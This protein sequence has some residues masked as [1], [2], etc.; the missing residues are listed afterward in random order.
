[1]DCNT[2]GSSVHGVSQAR[3]LEW[4]LISFS[5]GSSWARDWTWVSCISCIG[6]WLLYHW[7]TPWVM[8]HGFAKSWTQLSTWAPVAIITIRWM[9]M[10]GACLSV[11][12]FSL[13]S[14]YPICHLSSVSPI[15]YL[16]PIYYLSSIY[17][18]IYLSSKPLL[19]SAMLQWR[20]VNGSLWIHEQGCV[21]ICRGGIPR[22]KG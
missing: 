14:V 10:C 18:S 2:S 4:D 13:S 5:R 7:A 12:P 3:I 8:V 17:L 15:I 21:Q 6:M 1:M 11:Y 9:A 16:C 22:S 19:L 20:S